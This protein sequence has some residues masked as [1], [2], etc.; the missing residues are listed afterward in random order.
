MRKVPC[1]KDAPS[2]SFF[3]RD[4]TANFLNW[5]RCIGVDETYLFESEGLVLHKNPRQVYLCLLEIGRIVSRHGVEPPVLVKL[6]KE[7]EL[8]ETLLMSSDSIAPIVSYKSCCQHGE[9]HEAVKHIAED[10]PCSCSHRFSIEYL[11][12]GRYRLGDKI[13]FIRM[14]HGKHVMVR[15]GGGWDTLQGFLLKYD[16]CRMLQFATLEQKILSFQKGASGDTVSDSSAK[17][18]Q[19]PPMNPIS[20]IDAYHKQS[21][22]L[23]TMVSVSKNPP[24]KHLLP[25]DQLTRNQTKLKDS[26][27][28]NVQPFSKA[29]KP[30][31]KKPA[32]PHNPTSV[33]KYR[34]TVSKCSSSAQGRTA[35]T[36]SASLQKCAASSFKSAC[37]QN[38]PTVQHSTLSCSNN[39]L[40]RLPETATR[41]GSLEEH[42]SP[43]NAA[44]LKN[45]AKCKPLSKTSA[46]SA[47]T[48]NRNLHVSKPSSPQTSSTMPTKIISQNSSQTLPTQF[49]SHRGKLETKQTKQKTALSPKSSNSSLTNDKTTEQTS[50]LDV[51]SKNS[52]SSV[53]NNSSAKKRP[54][55]N[56]RMKIQVTTDATTHSDRMPLSIVRLPQTS[57]IRKKTVKSQAQVKVSQKND[58]GLD[59]TTKDPILKGKATTVPTKGT[60][61]RLNGSTVKSKQDDDYFVVT[62]NKK[63]R[64]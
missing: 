39:K 60:Q 42:H 5:C 14:L 18:P 29:S 61:I 64:K 40:S 1:K 58:K 11:S 33:S 59:S 3:A 63:L 9:L 54:V 48:I 37:S 25:T 30:V 17:P 49:Y 23:S 36:P 43:N 19:P 31:S 38:S 22:K 53:N 55:Q 41:V 57:T 47:K 15:V 34:Q 2:G 45:V 24:A 28:N 56:S 26:S 12:E 46:K 32:P 27:V 62:G 16:P 50:T 10:P 35:L 44:G 4:N 51:K 21:S 13:L 6:E 7:I 20:A 8:E 52:F